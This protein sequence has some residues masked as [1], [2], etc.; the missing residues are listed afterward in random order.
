[1]ITVSQV[2]NDKGLGAWTIGPNATVFEALKL[3]A[4]KDIGAL[5][6]VEKDK[7]I[8][9]LSERDYARKIV[10]LDRHSQDTPVH[11]IMTTSIYVVHPESTAE[12]CMALMTDKRIRHLPVLKDGILIGLVSIGD[13]VAAIISEQKFNIEN[14]EN[15]ITGK[16]H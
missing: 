5:I 13:V 1:M 15:Y 4:E 11:D 12:E 10:L 2:L 14:L 3:M 7:I 8:G 9:M 6:V 16:Y